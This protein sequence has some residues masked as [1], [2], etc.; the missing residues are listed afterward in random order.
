MAFSRCAAIIFRDMDM[1]KHARRM[2]GMECS[3]RILLFDIGVK[4]IVENTETSLAHAVG[5]GDALLDGVQQMRL[6]PV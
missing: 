4:G 1:R 6:E 5:V 2:R 3:Q